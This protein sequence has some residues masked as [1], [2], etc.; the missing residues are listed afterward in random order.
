MSPRS[1]L[2]RVVSRTYLSGIAA[3]FALSLS[4][5]IAAAGTPNFIII[6]VDDLGYADT[7]AF[8]GKN[9]TPALDRMAKEGRKMMS[10]YAAPVCSPS[11]SALMTGC[12]PKR[13]L[14][15]PGVLFP[16]AAA[17]L[18]PDEMT[19]AEVLK[20]G[21]Y[22]TA[23]IGKWHLGD[24][25]EFLPTRQGFDYYYGLPYSNDMGPAADG[26]KNN[27]GETS[28]ESKMKQQAAIKKAAGDMKPGP[29]APNKGNNNNNKKQQPNKNNGANANAE[30]G[31]VGAATQPPLA[32]IENDK[33]IARI[34]G[35]DQ[36]TLTTRY[37]EKALDFIRQ[38][39]EKPFFL[40]LPHNAVH[41]P[42][43]PSPEFRGKRPGAS[44]Q[45]SWVEEV[46]HSTGRILD[47]LRELKLDEKTLVIFT[48][49]N[50]G[51]LKQGAEN[52][53]L[54]GGKTETWEGG[55]RV[56]TIAW[57]PGHIPAGTQS[58]AIT[59][60]MDI[61][62]TFASLAGVPLPAQRKLD[63]VD[64]SPVLLGDPAKAPR[65]HYFIYKGLKLEALRLREWKLHLGTNELYQLEDDI[66]ETKNVAAEH[67]DVVKELRAFA[68]TMDGDL[69]LDGK[70]PG[71]RP[72]GRVDA[73]KP[74][75]SQDGAVRSDMVGPVASFP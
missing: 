9:P 39:K 27:P 1:L 10:H 38:N 67:Q 70:G 26:T 54:R 23:C 13:V 60:M 53:P 30:T 17:G 21:G 11:R 50:G 52:T 22:A 66:G 57:W 34:K 65:D 72:L 18:S 41:F 42:M 69:G 47:L 62:P 73:P 44:L 7:S 20:Q 15:I 48:S 46:S 5:T 29:K 12:Y 61:L 8:G 35:E 37:T 14:S 59:S 36:A 32:L 49:D 6:N 56:C 75:I 25:P 74:L 33:V 45:N 31:I 28:D 51:P 58:D 24:Q 40:Y 55:V 71:C 43:Y 4:S 64:V 3:A 2:P 19:I 68:Q 16:V 63:G